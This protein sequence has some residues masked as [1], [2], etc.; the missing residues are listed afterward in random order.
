MMTKQPKKRPKG[1]VEAMFNS[2]TIAFKPTTTIPGNVRR[3]TEYSLN[4]VKDWTEGDFLSCLKRALR[5]AIHVDQSPP[6]FS[7]EVAN[8]KLATRHWGDGHGL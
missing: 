5:N 8:V 1:R 4:R 6:S 3:S 2:V 7:R